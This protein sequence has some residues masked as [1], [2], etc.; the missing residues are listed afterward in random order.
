MCN[1]YQEK[2]TLFGIPQVQIYVVATGDRDAAS[3]DELLDGGVLHQSFGNSVTA[4]VGQSTLGIGTVAADAI[5]SEALKSRLG[6]IQLAH[7][8]VSRCHCN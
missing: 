8:Q 7:M 3:P 2:A 5:V 6:P 4:L 1:E